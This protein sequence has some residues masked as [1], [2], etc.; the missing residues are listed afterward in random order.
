MGQKSY[1]VEG[2]KYLVEK[3]TD[4]LVVTLPEGQLIDAALGNK[5]P[6]VTDGELYHYLG[7]RHKTLECGYTLEH[8]DLVISYGYWRRIKRPLFEL[9]KIGCVNF[10][11]APL[12][13]FRGMGGVYNFAIYEKI[14]YWGVSAHFVDKSFDTGDLIEVR[15]FPINPQQE[16]A[17]TLREKSHKY[18]IALFKDVIDTV[19]KGGH[20]ARSTQG[21]GRYI[22]RQDFEK[23]RKVQPSDSLDEINRKIRAFW[24]PPY[25]GAYIELHNKEFT[26]V[27]DELLER[28]SKND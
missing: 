25:Q 12:P 6:V 21:E 28:I 9:P 20:L 14:T 10:H 4:V 22:S 17:F 8:I 19:C 27:N 5:L 3:G 13:E 16:T 23:L 15:R 7:T 2:L 24:C 26:L 18:L 1:S 11:P